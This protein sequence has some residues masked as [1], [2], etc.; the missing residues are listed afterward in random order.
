MSY[1]MQEEKKQTFWQVMKRLLEP[2]FFLKKEMIIISFVSC[3]QAFQVI[4]GIR[5][6]AEIVRAFET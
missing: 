5:N 1:N 4:F 6:S 3:F 2:A